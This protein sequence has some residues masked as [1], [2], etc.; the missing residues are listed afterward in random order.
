MDGSLF[1]KLKG[2]SNKIWNYL[3]RIQY[4]QY[5]PQKAK[6]KQEQQTHSTLESA[7]LSPSLFEPQVTTKQKGSLA[8]RCK[9]DTGL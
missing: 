2:Q 7:Q 6:Q 4:W 3:L 9:L 5:W 1:T 8:E